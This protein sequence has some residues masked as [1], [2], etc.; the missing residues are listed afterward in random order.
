MLLKRFMC[1]N[2]LEGILLMSHQWKCLKY[3]VSLGQNTLNF[4]WRTFTHCTSMCLTASLVIL[5]KKG[6]KHMPQNTLLRSVSRPKCCIGQCSW[7]Y[8]GNL[9]F[10]SK[11]N[12]L[13]F[14]NQ[15]LTNQFQRSTNTNYC[16]CKMKFAFPRLD[17]IC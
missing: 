1:I 2:T 12:I 10:S 17:T 11:L 16:T 9:F 4:K 3:T 6:A 14:H 13:C 8:N 7:N 15:A 5:D